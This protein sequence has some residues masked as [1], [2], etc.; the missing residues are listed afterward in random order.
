M[1]DLLL[2]RPVVQ[3]GGHA[4]ASSTAAPTADNLHWSAAALCQ[5]QRPPTHHHHC[6]T[7]MPYIIYKAPLDG[8][9][10][11]S[12]CHSIAPYCSRSKVEQR[13]SVSGAKPM[14]AVLKERLPQLDRLT[15][16]LSSGTATIDSSAGN[17]L[18]YGTACCDD[19]I[20]ALVC[21]WLGG[22]VSSQLSLMW[23]AVCGPHV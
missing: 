13:Q 18:P 8:R 1:S 9:H 7:I 15:D 4:A 16:S 10:H 22:G 17:R 19:C 14:L 20:C 2:T 11:R 12:A 3:H 23:E 21:C 6:A 5:L